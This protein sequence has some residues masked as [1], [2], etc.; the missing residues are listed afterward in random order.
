[1]RGFGYL[2]QTGNSGDQ[3]E[4]SK[5]FVSVPLRGFGYLKQYLN[6]TKRG[7]RNYVSVPLRG[8]G[9]LKRVTNLKELEDV[10]KCFRPLAGIWLS[11]TAARDVGRKDFRNAVSVPLRGFGYL[12]LGKPSLVGTVLTRGVSVP[13][14]G[15]GY[16]K[17]S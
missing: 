15:F 5:S 17:R 7:R 14:R 9:Y 3:F 12:K 6:P 1:M 2:K 4:I 13:L 10:Y 11:K 8:F 16:L